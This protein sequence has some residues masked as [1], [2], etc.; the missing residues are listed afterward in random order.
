MEACRG[1][2]F[3]VGAFLDVCSQSQRLSA[4]SRGRDRGSLLLME[5]EAVE[6]FSILRIS[7]VASKETEGIKIEGCLCVKGAGLRMSMSTHKS[8]SVVNKYEFEYTV[9]TSFTLE[10]TLRKSRVE[11]G[12]DL[13]SPYVVCPCLHTQWS[14]ISGLVRGRDNDLSQGVNKPVGVEPSRLSEQEE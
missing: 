4:S 14:H 13:A 7:P 6:M 2:S 12:W 3:T 1:R 11:G 5:G 8:E 9:K 10:V